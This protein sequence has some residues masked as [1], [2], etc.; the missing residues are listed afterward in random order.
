MKSYLVLLPAACWFGILLLPAQGLEITGFADLA[1][2]QATYPADS[3]LYTSRDRQPLA[4]SLRLL[5]EGGE[6]EL[7]FSANLL[8][9]VG[10]KPPLDPD[11]AAQLPSEVERSALLTWEQYDSAH[12]RAVLA[13]DVLQF[14]YRGG[15][16]DLALGRQPVSL[17]TT[18]YFVPND[19]FAPFAAQSFFRTY[20]PGVDAFRA[21]LRLAPLSQLTLLAV[22]AYE[23]DPDSANGWRRGPEWSETA[24]LARYTDELAGFGWNLLGGTVRE[25]TVLGGAL[26]GELFDW[27]GVRGEG[28][29]AR[30]ERD[31]LA[32]GGG[33]AAGVEHRYANNFNWRL[34]YYYHGYRDE[35]LPAHS[36]R[37]YAALGLGWEFTPL[38]TGGLVAL[39]ALDDNS[40]LLTANLL[41]SLTDESEL[42]LT[43]AL[44]LGERPAGPN[45]GSEFGRQPRQLL[46][47]YR[48]YF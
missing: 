42:A 19:F 24:L 22:L 6:D 23:P 20:K 33:L 44:P 16:I 3:A 37:N 31:G 10:S 30:A 25:R 14:Q 11:L 21:D 47:E 48:T 39:A 41:Y 4:G 32:D 40:Q 43:A 38:L 2:G 7:H 35:A 28:H 26:Q 13:A 46:L 17:A 12:T 29:Y 18:F 36:G 5:A 9:A 1:V 34:E 15:A 8:E 45:Q 27:L